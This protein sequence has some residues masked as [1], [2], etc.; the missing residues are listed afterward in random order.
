MSFAYYDREAKMFGDTPLQRPSWPFEK[1][2]VKSNYANRKPICNFMFDGNS[3]AYPT[4]HNFRDIRSRN[5]H[6]LDVDL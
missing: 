2:K 6:D 1:A 4:C 5:V 3:N